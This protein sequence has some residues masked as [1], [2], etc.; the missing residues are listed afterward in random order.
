MNSVKVLDFS[1][2]PNKCNFY[3]LAWGVLSKFSQNIAYLT[4]YIQTLYLASIEVFQH[5][6][7]LNKIMNKLKI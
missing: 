5:Q 4:L 1:L 2:C 6:Y 7:K 3:F